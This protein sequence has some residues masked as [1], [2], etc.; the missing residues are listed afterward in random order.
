MKNKFNV[1]TIEIF[2]SH[3][4]KLG[5]EIYTSTLILDVYKVDSRQ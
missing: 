5:A 2:K 3:K 4:I 1:L